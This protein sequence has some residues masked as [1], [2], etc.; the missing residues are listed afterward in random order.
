MCA[1]TWDS[2]EYSKIPSLAMSRYT[3]SFRRNDTK[4]FNSYLDELSQGKTKVN[5]G[6][7]YPYDV[8][9]NINNGDLAQRQWES[10]P[11]YMVNC[12]DIILPLVDVSGSMTTNIPNSS[13]SPLQVAVSLGLYISERNVGPLQNYF[14]TFSSYPQLVHTV[15]TLK[16]R[17]HQMVTSDWGMNTDLIAVFKTLL[18]Q[19]V[20]NNVKASDMP[21]KIL[22]FSDMEFDSCIENSNNTAMES[23]KELYKSH[24][25]YLPK[26][27][28]WNLNSRKN[29]LPVRYDES[30]S[31][32]VSG[33]SPA[34][35][36]SILSMEISNPHS[37]MINTLN[38][39]K[40]LGIVA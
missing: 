16:E 7:I 34:I 4:R 13:L 27:V 1:K 37:I 12:H 10:L 30:G 25:Y 11:D 14:M 18:N 38:D 36:K 20:K 33:F 2:I 35:L 17:F 29:N 28:F 21:T 23:I 39:Y 31:A 32:L 15:G 24:G 40:Y 5:V 22:I 6:A 8:I 3:M 9:K 26:I 19:S